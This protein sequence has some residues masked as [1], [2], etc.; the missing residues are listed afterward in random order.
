MRHLKHWIQNSLIIITF[1]LIV[2]IVSIN[3]FSS[4]LAIPMILGLIAIIMINYNILV[5]F[6]KF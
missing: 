3:D 4:Y 2:M 5:K 6:G 1:L